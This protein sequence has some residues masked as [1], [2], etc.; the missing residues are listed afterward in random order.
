MT[1]QSL[2]LDTLL[3]YMT[4]QSLILDTIALYDYAEHKSLTQ[5]L[6]M[7]MQS[8]NPWHDTSLYDYGEPIPWHSIAPYDYAEEYKICLWY[9]QIQVWILTYGIH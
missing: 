3:L 2:I 9:V 7:T 8:I 4:V 5:L 1:V 6:Y